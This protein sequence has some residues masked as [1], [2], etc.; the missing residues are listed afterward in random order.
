MNLRPKS[1]SDDPRIEIAPLI[2]VVF[3]LLLFFLLTTTFVRHRSIDVLLPESGSAESMTDHDELVVHIGADGSVMFEGEVVDREVLQEA[4][5]RAEREEPGRVL[6][7][8]ADRDASHGSVV[9][10][11]D[12]AGSVG[13][14]RISIVTMGKD[15]GARDRLRDPRED[16]GEPPP[17]VDSTEPM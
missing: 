14:E 1:A 10:V 6:L 9:S 8:K 11:M 15:R 5:A 12:V 7:L 17:D 16:A 4:L 13:L 3:L 2:D